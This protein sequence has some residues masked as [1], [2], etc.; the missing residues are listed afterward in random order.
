MYVLDERF[1]FFSDGCL[2]I[3]DECMRNG[4]KVFEYVYVKTG[5]LMIFWEKN[6]SFFVLS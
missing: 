4:F 6:V 3:Y 2:S 5:F 1:T